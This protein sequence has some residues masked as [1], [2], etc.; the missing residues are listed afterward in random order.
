MDILIK[1]ARNH[2]PDA[3]CQLM[4]GQMNSMYKV[5]KAYLKND[6]DVADAIQDTILT[7]YEKIDTLKQNRYFK[8]WLTRILLNKCSDIQKEQ[9]RMTTID[10]IPETPIID[11]NFDNV[12]WNEILKS[13][14]EKY[15][16]IIILHYVEGFSAR[17]IAQ[18]LE[19]NENTVKARILRGRTILGKAYY[20]VE[21]KEEHV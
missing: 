3:F 18:L 9:K 8:T 21:A 7:C 17:E 5:A 15:R 13:I 1:K 20:S 2:D 10:A 16:I 4:D 6:E 11:F 19:M 14:D 12:E